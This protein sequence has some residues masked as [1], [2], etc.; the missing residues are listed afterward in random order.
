MRR[1]FGTLGLAAFF[2]LLVCLPA[3]AGPICNFCGVQLQGVANT[4]VAGTFSVNSSGVFSNIS[5]SFTGNSMF[6]GVQAVDNKSIQGLWIQG[7]GWMFSWLT[8]VGGN[9]ICYSVLFN[10]ATNQ[11]WAGGW[12]D[13]GQNGGDFNYL[14]VP[15]GGAILSYLFLSG[16]AMF[17]GI[18]M[19]GKQRHTARKAS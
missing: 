10:P 19:S 11:F 13:K 15:E 17:A 14:Q 5:I 16:A 6:G 1:Y 8:K 3:S 4:T 18:V 12:I 7:K 9:L 2:L